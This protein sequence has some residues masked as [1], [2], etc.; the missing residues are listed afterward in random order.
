MRLHDGRVVPAL[1][2]A[3]LRGE[4]LN[5]F[6]DGSQ[7]RSFCYVDD[8]L[9]G[10]CRLMESDEHLPTNIGNPV[11]MSILEFAKSVNKVVGSNFPIEFTPLPKDDPKIRKPDITKAKALLDWAPTID[12]ETG[13]AM[14]LDY[15]KERVAEEAQN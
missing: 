6:G 12:L 15:F 13:L 8:L 7:T 2:G 4:P 5:I 11:E 9:E 14:S 3:A 1:M 10:I